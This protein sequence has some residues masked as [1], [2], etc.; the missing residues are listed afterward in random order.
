MTNR[1]PLPRKL[2]SSFKPTLKLFVIALVTYLGVVYNF[3]FSQA[4]LG[5]RK[6]IL[7]AVLTMDL[8]IMVELVRERL[9]IFNKGL[10]R[11]DSRRWFHT[12]LRSLA[13][14]S[15]FC[16]VLLHAD[17]VL[18]RFR[19]GEQGVT[20]SLEGIKL[21]ILWAQMSYVFLAAWSKWM[22]TMTATFP[23]PGFDAADILLFSLPLI[24]LVNYLA[25][26]R[27]DFSLLTAVE[28]LM[29]FLLCP[30][31]VFAFIQFIQQVLRAGGIAAP[32]VAGLAFV[33]YSTPWVSALFK[34]PVEALLPVQI[35]LALIIPILLAVAYRRAKRTTIKRVVI[36]VLCSVTGS[37]VQATYLRDTK[38]RPLSTME[39]TPGG[40]SDE[41]TL[42]ELLSAPVKRRPDVYLLIYD[43][44]APFSMLKYHGLENASA[45]PYL[46]SQGFRIYDEAYSLFLASK[47]SMSS[48][49]DMRAIPR[50]GI[51]R[52][53]RTNEF[54]QRQGYKTHMVLNSYLLQGRDR[55]MAD[56]VFPPWRYRSGL[57]ALY[58]GIG[59]GE[60]KAEIVFGDCPRDEWLAAKQAVFTQ[61]SSPKMLYAHSGVPGHSQLSGKCLDDETAK[62]AERLR[63]ANEEMKRDVEMILQTHRDAIIIVAGDH[64]PYLTGDCRYM[65][66]Q[67]PEDLSSVHF[68]DRYGMLLAIRWPRDKVKSLERI[69]VL[70]DVF[71]A[72]ASYLLEDERVW[73][74]RLQVATAGYGGIPDGAVRNGIVMIGKDKGRRLFER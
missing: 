16:V 32:V 63:V 5:P 21:N 29:F 1:L 22:F 38:D 6:A 13:Y 50:V 69:T 2:L 70:Q 57:S 27:A 15:L 68:A 28:Y 24:P 58:R 54:F 18:T 26:N 59:G 45:S 33:Y 51:G 61:T 4:A 62:Y 41:S 42:K 56:S 53:T 65:A 66:R 12:L 31:A 47:A 7:L 34:R 67:R 35:V 8:L 49:L 36:G 23:S 11:A 20:G 9:N 3:S 43:G 72:V 64:G 19:G 55:I 73:A 30:I 17:F 71:F 14:A 10:V 44:Y 25:Q 39:S 48:V 37:F 46:R 74:H 40:N 60:F 52:N